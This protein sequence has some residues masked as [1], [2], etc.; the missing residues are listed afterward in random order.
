[1]TQNGRLCVSFT[2]FQTSNIAKLLV[3]SPDPSGRRCERHPAG[4]AEL[5]SDRSAC[6]KARFCAGRRN[7]PASEGAPSTNEAC[8]WTSGCSIITQPKLDLV[9]MENTDSW[10]KWALWSFLFF[11][12]SV[13]G[14][15]WAWVQRYLLPRG[16]RTCCRCSAASGQRSP[17]VC[18]Y[19]CLGRPLPEILFSSTPPEDKWVE[20]L[21]CIL[22]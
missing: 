21:T 2:S 4:S 20:L 16:R 14:S 22:I 10:N 3:S 15:S 13:Q 9:Y 8:G 11:F 1:M 18:C 19:K 17:T 7:Q 12:T 5:E 6:P